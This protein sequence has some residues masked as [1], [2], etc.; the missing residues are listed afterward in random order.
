MTLKA[1]KFYPF[2][3]GWER[4]TRKVH[5]VITWMD[6]VTNWE[7]PVIGIVRRPLQLM[8]IKKLCCNT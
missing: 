3:H 2:S 5:I 7:S 4:R 1:V 8:A 6:L